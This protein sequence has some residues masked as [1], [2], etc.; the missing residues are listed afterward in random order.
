[1]QRLGEAED[2]LEVGCGELGRRERLMYWVGK[3]R[4]VLLYLH[5]YFLSQ[6]LGEGGMRMGM[7]YLTTS[8]WQ[9]VP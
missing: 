2:K 9:P 6:G 7:A 1:V 8:H 3:E 5:Q 4:D